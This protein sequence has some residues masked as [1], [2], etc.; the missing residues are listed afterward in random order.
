MECLKTNTWEQNSIHVLDHPAAQ[1]NTCTYTHLHTHYNYYRWIIQ[2]NYKR[3]KQNKGKET[4]AK[5]YM[6]QWKQQETK[7]TDLSIC[8]WSSTKPCASRGVYYRWHKGHNSAAETPTTREISISH[9]WHVR[10]LF[11]TWLW[12][13]TNKAEERTTN[14]EA[15]DL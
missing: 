10:S 12:R 9:F 15:A 1:V 13:Q 14:D 4:K 6:M 7:T 2:N 3:K 5:E 8:N 11:V